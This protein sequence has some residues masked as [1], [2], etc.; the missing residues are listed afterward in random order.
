MPFSK[1][2]NISRRDFLKYCGGF[3]VFGKK[4]V[5]GRDSREFILDASLMALGGA[6]GAQLAVEFGL[7]ESTKI[8]REEFCRKIAP[9]ILV[10]SL[11]GLALG[12]LILW[13]EKV[14]EVERILASLPQSP[15]ENVEIAELSLP[16][17]VALINR[18]EGKLPTS[19]G[20]DVLLTATAYRA[21]RFLGEPPAKARDH[22]R[23]VFK[24]F[25][26]EEFRAI[27]KPRAGQDPDAV[28][29]C[30][31]MFSG[32]EI[33]A[34]F[35]FSQEEWR[36]LSAYGMP[37]LS[38]VSSIAHEVA[39]MTIHKFE[40]FL[41]LCSRPQEDYGV[42]GKLEVFSRGG[43]IR[44]YLR[45]E[46]EDLTIDGRLE[47]EFFAEWAVYR[48]LKELE[49]AG[50]KEEPFPPMGYP[51]F[52]QAI[53]NLELPKSDWPRWWRGVMDFNR[54]DRFHWK[55]DLW[56]FRR[57]IGKVIQSYIQ[58]YNQVPLKLDEANMA[59]LGKL[60]FEA[61]SHTDKKRLDHLLQ[62]SD[63]EELL[64]L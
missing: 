54:V 22:A 63:K 38:R 20:M 17:L 60:A 47:E 33:W 59:A 32:G 45:L 6:A 4:C 13:R 36:Q 25:S 39:H 27:C 14:K 18:Q 21:A 55:N 42:L 2:R 37:I 44:N 64:D 11:S 43:F 30:N 48:F 61:F 7:T 58:V 29:A 3:P 19:E 53:I 24:V 52:F 8:T 5:L 28:S 15:V 49:K 62:I 9:G 35:N 34:C 23:R 57:D 50:L 56:R 10:G 51:Q 26:E 1:E 12:E 31:A 41:R 16:E 46:G 40:V